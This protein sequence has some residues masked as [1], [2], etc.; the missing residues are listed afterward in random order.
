MTIFI[1]TYYLLFIITH[2]LTISSF[3]CTLGSSERLKIEYTSL[4]LRRMMMLKSK[5]RFMSFKFAC[6]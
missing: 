3:N 2:L 5:D 6:K 1:I 4:I